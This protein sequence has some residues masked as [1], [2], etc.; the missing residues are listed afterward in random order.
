MVDATGATTVGCA[1]HVSALDTLVFQYHGSA[2]AIDHPNAVVLCPQPGCHAAIGQH[3]ALCGQH[4][5][6]GQARATGA[7]ADLVQRLH[8]PLD[9]THAAPGQRLLQGM[10]YPVRVDHTLSR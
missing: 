1:K 8:Y 7:A 4:T 2:D 5:A 6:I 3:H 9:K 10:H